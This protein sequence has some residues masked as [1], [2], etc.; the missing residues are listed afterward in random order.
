MNSYGTLTLFDFRG[1]KVQTKCD[2]CQQKQTFEGDWLIEKR[3]NE[4]MPGMLKVLAR[5]LECPRVENVYKDRCML[6]YAAESRPS[7]LPAVE[8]PSAKPT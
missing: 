6:H 5:M 1:K 2:V 8:P 7:P 4:D 3:G